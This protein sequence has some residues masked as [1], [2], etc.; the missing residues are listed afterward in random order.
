MSLLQVHT[1]V[2]NS[3]T[4]IVE[5]LDQ[6]TTHIECERD[7]DTANHQSTV[8]VL[9]QIIAAAQSELDGANN[10]INDINN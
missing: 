2:G 3:V 7:W 1:G 10:R 8:T 9:E 5:L 6:I 4:A